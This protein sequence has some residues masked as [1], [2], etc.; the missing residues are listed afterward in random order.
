MEGLL[1]KQG[2]LRCSLRTT[3]L[4]DPRIV[5]L[6]VSSEHTHILQGGA[7]ARLGPSGVRLL[8]AAPVTT[9]GSW[10]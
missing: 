9:L 4:S 10:G 3:K 7:P 2:A 8:D 1:S 6:I 5:M